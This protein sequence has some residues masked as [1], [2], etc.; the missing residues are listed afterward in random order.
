MPSMKAHSMP[1]SPLY[2]LG[3]AVVAAV[4]LGTSAQVNAQAAGEVEFSR[5]V[6]FAQS[7]GQIPRTLG[8][9]L[10]L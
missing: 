8:K 1:I 6:G 10:P 5:G 4:L 7:E 2:R 9:G 3:F